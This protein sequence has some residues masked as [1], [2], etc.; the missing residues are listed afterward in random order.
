MFYFGAILFSSLFI[1]SFIKDRHKIINAIY[2]LLALA[3]I[4]FSLVT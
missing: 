4:Y 2:F 3:F 1:Y